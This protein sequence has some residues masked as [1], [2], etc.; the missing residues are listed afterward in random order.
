MSELCT[1]V[2]Y[3]GDCIY[4]DD[5][6]I[7]P[8]NSVDLIYLDPP[9]S[10]NKNYSANYRDSSG[11]KMSFDDMWKGKLEAYI[12][13]MRPRLVQMKR[14]LKPTGSIYY[15]CDYH[16]NH[17]VRIIL[18]EIFGV[19]NFRN[20]IIWHYHTGGAS[21]SH[22]SKKHDTIFLYSNGR[23]YVFNA[24]REP[25][26]ED[27]SDHF[28]EID[29]DGRRY[30]IREINGKSYKYYLDDG[31]VCD[32]VWDISAV[33]AVAKERVG[34]PTQKPIELLSRIILAS[35][36]D[37]DVVLDP[38][39]GSGSTCVTAALL[40]RKFIGIDVSMNACDVAVSRLRSQAGFDIKMDDIKNLIGKDVPDVIGGESD[41][42]KYMRWLAA[43]DPFKFQSVCCSKIGAEVTLKKSDDHGRDGITKDG[44]PV[45]VKG[46]DKVGRG[47]LQQFVGTIKEFNRKAGVFIAFSFARSAYEYASTIKRNDGIDIKLMS[48]NDLPRVATLNIKTLDKFPIPPGLK[49]KPR[50][51]VYGGHIQRTL[52]DF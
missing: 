40:K 2:I 26:R 22:F 39:C 23:S 18:D 17:Y 38:F 43:N 37:G 9:F 51:D 29:D 3:R 35:S 28:K 21:K 31:K 16:A 5:D 32:D 19:K 4:M 1:N 42:M 8:D 34:Y 36:N 15:H 44:D 33:N 48:V 25:F 49:R 46:S 45:Q 12:D 52:L 47:K 14:V 20:E 50:T 24:Q 10:S 27:K 41:T 13:Y 11:V 7:F 30:R 6:D